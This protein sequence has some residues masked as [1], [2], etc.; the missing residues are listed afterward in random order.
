MTTSHKIDVKIGS[1]EEKAWTEIRKAAVARIKESRR[2]L[3]INDAV[4]KL[5]DERIR[6][7]KENFK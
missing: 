3:L 7:E 4:I 2:E 1:V 5:A 6:I